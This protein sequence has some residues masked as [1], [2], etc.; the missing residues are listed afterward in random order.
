VIWP[1]KSSLLLLTLTYPL[2]H[3]SRGDM[4]SFS[5]KVVKFLHHWVP[6]LRQSKLQ[7]RSLS[8]AECRTSNRIRTPR[9]KTSSRWSNVTKGSRQNRCISSV[10]AL[11][12]RVGWG[13]PV[14]PKGCGSLSCELRR[15]VRFA[16]R[17]TRP[18]CALVPSSSIPNN[19][20]G[21]VTDKGNP[22]V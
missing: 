10:K 11:A 3:T 20:L 7:G 18:T 8:L 1:Y 13:R 16:G 6:S 14:T 4:G 12:P 5:E 22:T 9:S 21:T 17:A 15:Q 19:Q 2:N